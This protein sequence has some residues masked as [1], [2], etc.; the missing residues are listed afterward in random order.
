VS[1]AI[2]K[3]PDRY[4]AEI[5]KRSRWVWDVRLA[6]TH[7]IPTVGERGELLEVR[8]VETFRDPATVLGARWARW[9][10]RRMV[11]AAHRR[12]V[13]EGQPWVVTDG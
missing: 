5:R 9:K 4:R 11:A 12:D 13:R 10:G 8:M 7:R 2:D 1:H 3:T 6:A